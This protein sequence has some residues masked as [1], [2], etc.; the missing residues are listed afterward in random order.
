VAAQRLGVVLDTNCCGFR[1]AECVDAQQEGQSAVV[2]GD[3]LNDL[4][5]RISSNR[6]KPWVRVSS[7]WIFGSRT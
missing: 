7:A 3:D 2:N 5:N 1:G 6:S 4:E